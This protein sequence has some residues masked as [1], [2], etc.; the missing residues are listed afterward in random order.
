MCERWYLSFPNFFADMGER[1]SPNHSI[2]RIDSTGPYSPE[3]CRW[4]TDIE[5]MNNHSHNRLITYQG[6]TRTIAEWARLL[7]IPY[8]RLRGRIARNVPTERA[9]HPD[10]LHDRSDKGKHRKPHT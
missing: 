1:P 3:N 10:I 8:N 7:N 2:E 4:A 6:E 5:Q 9:F